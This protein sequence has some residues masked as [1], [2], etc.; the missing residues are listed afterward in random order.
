EVPEFL[1]ARYF[2]S[3]EN[4]WRIAKQVRDMCVFA[5]H[6]V[7]TNAPFSNVDLVSVRNFLIY[8]RKTAKRQAFEVFFYALRRGGYLLLGPSETADPELFEE[9]QPALNLYRRRQISRPPLRGFSFGELPP[10]P[11]APSGELATPS[12]E[13][14]VDRLAIARYAP[15]GFVVDANGHVVQF[16]GDTS[17]LLQPTSGDAAL[18]L[19]K[20]V[21]EEL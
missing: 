2:V 20:L 13:S 9:S 6:N 1:R 19:A 5:V 15:P 17:P 18:S 10:H 12:L 21:R 3:D 7:F 4:G 11:T 8:L 14:L 16:R